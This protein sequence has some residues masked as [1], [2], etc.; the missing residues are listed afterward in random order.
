MSNSYE[1]QSEA[2]RVMKHTRPAEH[3][4]PTRQ[5]NASFRTLGF[6]PQF[7]KALQ[8]AFPNV[9]RPT[10]VQEKLILEILGGRD[11]L[12]KDDTGSGKTFG[13]VL[14]LLNKPRMV[15]HEY[16][17]EGKAVGSKRVVTTLFIVPHRDLAFQL[18]HWIE[19][20]TS[21]LAPRPP[22]A[23]I[24]QVLVRGGS[25]SHELLVAEIRERA[26]HILICTPQALMEVYKTDAEVLQLSTLSAVVVDEVDYLVET[27]ARKDPKKSYLK[28]FEKAR[29]KVELHPGQTRE[30]LDIIYAQRKALSE[31]PYIPEED[32]ENE[33]HSVGEWR[34]AAEEE[35][36]IPQLIL[37]SATL[38]VGLKNYL[39]EESKWVNSHNLVKIFAEKGSGPREAGSTPVKGGRGNILH[40]ILVVSAD[41]VRNVEGAVASA[42][43]PQEER[44]VFEEVE[45]E[46]VSAEEYYNEKYDRTESPFDPVALE[47]V[48]AGFALDV[49]SAALLV[50]PSSA[51]VQ[52][53][54][55][56]LRRLGVNA[57]GLDLLAEERGRAYLN[58]GGDGVVRANP[59]L[60]VAT[61]ATTRGLDLPEL[62]HVFVLG[63]P[64]GP[65]VNGR[66]VDAYMHIA[67][68]VGRFGR[69]G[70]VVSVVAEAE[71]AKAVRIVE[72]VEDSDESIGLTQGLIPMLTGGRIAR[73]GQ[74]QSLARSR[75]Q[76]IN[77]RRVEH[78]EDPEH[79]GIRYLLYNRRSMT[80]MQ[81]RVTRAAGRK[82]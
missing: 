1:A 9:K 41:G 30:I 6:D 44:Q 62:T 11:I 52:R 71:R 56:E 27:V 40:S 34:N 50:V 5:P 53:A 80:T 68:R 13:L 16:S 42:P 81:L 2:L 79:P 38:R 63:L 36:R 24:A 29:R 15:M 54:V 17:D 7:M 43:F 19:R 60:L 65:S 28:A 14:G 74:I 75:P 55:Y 57:H 64:C 37:S 70:R 3:R 61:L 32:E 66:A 48:A 82:R 78:R 33:H 31:N 39:F 20:L 45:E 8:T 49:P 76:R 69:R 22:L 47:A 4:R 59:V 10:A 26:P 67:G 51:P 21:A 12:L 23:S 35:A 25:K 72:S 46:A 18:L 58:H 73:N 77:T